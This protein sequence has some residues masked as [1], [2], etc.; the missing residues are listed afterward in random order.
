MDADIHNFNGIIE[1]WLLLHDPVR[2]F[3]VAQASVVYCLFV[4]ELHCLLTDLQ[5]HSD[6]FLL[7][8]H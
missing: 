7:L 3:T 8:Q 4:L 1:F 6:H 2:P 5:L